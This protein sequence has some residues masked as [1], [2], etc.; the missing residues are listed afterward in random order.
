MKFEEPTSHNVLPSDCK[1]FAYPLYAR[2][3]QIGQLFGISTPTVY[4]ILRSMR[5]N[6][7]Y[8]WSV[9][10]VG[11]ATSLVNIRLFEEYLIASNGKWLTD[12]KRAKNA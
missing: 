4:R 8:K 6:P 1:I 12:F 7:K 3:S 2:K 10:S 9:I 11:S 5:D